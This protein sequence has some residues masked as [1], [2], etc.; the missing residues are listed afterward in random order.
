MKVFFCSS[1][2]SF[3]DKDIY[4]DQLP[5]DVIAITEELRQAL[6]EAQSAGKHIIADKNGN[7]IAVERPGPTFEQQI[8]RERFWRNALLVK[9]DALV[10]RHRD[11]QDA[12]RETSLT[13]VQYKQMQAYRLDLRSWPES[14][15]FP[16]MDHRPH[17]PTWLVLKTV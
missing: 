14:P 2:A 9:T 4:G 13:D 1:S 15:N 11:E 12:A 16:S 7:P 8:D 3:Y 5:Y 10:T 17:T 6:L